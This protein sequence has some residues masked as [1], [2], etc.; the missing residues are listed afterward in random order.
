MWWLH[1]WHKRE[2]VVLK[3]KRFL[4]TFFF[5]VAVSY[6]SADKK[7]YSTYAEYKWCKNKRDQKLLLFVL[8]VV[9]QLTR[10]KWTN[11]TSHNNK[12]H[13]LVEGRWEDEWMVVT[14]E[15]CRR[16]HKLFH[17]LAILK[18]ETYHCLIVMMEL[19]QPASTWSHKCLQEL[20]LGFLCPFNNTFQQHMLCR[21]KSQGS[22]RYK[23]LSHHFPSGKTHA[24][25]SSDQFLNSEIPKCH[26]T[27][28][29]KCD[30]SQAYFIF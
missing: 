6:R 18:F 9:L 16:E 29:N 4:L 12:I 21:V 11:H 13:L 1:E 5:I 24:S 30:F 2:T 15:A 7:F 8:P 20:I 22:A 19:Y 14:S 3:M 25:W 26:S 17:L 10:T 28:L 27:V 23:V